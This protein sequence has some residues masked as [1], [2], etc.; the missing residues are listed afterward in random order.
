MAR[1]PGAKGNV[2]KLFVEIAT[3]RTT[4]AACYL[5]VRIYRPFW[6]IRS[7]HVAKN[8]SGMF[9]FLSPAD[10]RENVDT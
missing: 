1:C 9:W 8:S 10:V 2:R 4:K 3:S 7:R 6:I 5:I